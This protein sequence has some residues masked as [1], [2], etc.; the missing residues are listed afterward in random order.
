MAGLRGERLW[1]IPLTDAATDPT[2]EPIAQLTDVYGR[3]RTVA[4]RAGRQPVGE[5]VEH[6]RARRRPGRR[7]PD[8]AAGV[9]ERSS[10]S[11]PQSDWPRR[12]LST[13][14]PDAPLARAACAL[15]SGND[16]SR[17]ARAAARRRPVCSP[18]VRPDPA[19]AG[20]PAPG[21]P[22]APHPAPGRCRRPDR[23]G[24]GDRADPARCPGRRGA[25]GGHQ[26][27]ADR[28]PDRGRRPADR[29]RR[30]RPGRGDPRPGGRCSA[31]SWRVR[32]GAARS[33]PTCG[34]R[35]R[36]GPT[37]DRAGWRCRCGPPTRRSSTCSGRACTSR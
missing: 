30:R 22:A 8:P 10:A 35:T 7:R 5:H 23:R 26:G 32:R 20:R 6:R 21:R 16:A 12:R 27:P 1:Q 9:R 2:G 11:C 36:S 29:A 14:S 18:V 25:G 19:I 15:A 33:S 28:R 31:G 13:M 4:G 24:R 3:L 37:R 17:A 34:W